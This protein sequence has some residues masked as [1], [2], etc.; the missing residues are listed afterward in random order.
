MNSARQRLLILGSRVFAEEVADLADDIPDV[1]LVGFVENLER[2]RC[3]TPL[4]G[5]P[6]YWI[7]DIKPLIEDHRAVCALGTTHRSQLIIQAAALGVQFTTL[8]HPTARVS[9]KTA[10]GDG[11]IISVGTIIAAHSQLNGHV[12]VNR[13]A[14]IGHHTSIG[15]FVTVGP[16]ANI[17]GQ[18]MIGK[19]VYIGMSAV[20]LDGITIGPHAIVGAGAVVTK[21]VPANVQ[22]VGVP[23]R[24]VKEN[25]DGH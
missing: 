19:G 7:D 25:V 22:V 23:A 8:I 2:E 6:V 17:A 13:G 5:L 18:C 10:L 14:M 11:C 4:L 21:D 12:I 15:E 1:Q 9:R 16:G 24:I 3:A 20:V